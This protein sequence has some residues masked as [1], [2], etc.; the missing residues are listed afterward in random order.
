[1]TKTIERASLEQ[2]IPTPSYSELIIDTVD[3]LAYMRC[4]GRSRN[5]EN[6]EGGGRQCEHFFSP[7]GRT[8]NKTCTK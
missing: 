6:G 2:L 3:A 8:D 4:S 7:E 5:V 1:M